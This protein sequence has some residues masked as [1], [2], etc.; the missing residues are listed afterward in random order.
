VRWGK[1]IRGYHRFVYRNWVYIADVQQAKFIVSV[2]ISL[3]RP[4]T[5][6]S[7]LCDLYY[8]RGGDHCF[9]TKS[10]EVDRESF[11][12]VGIRI[13]LCSDRCDCCHTAADPGY[14]TKQDIA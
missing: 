4:I 9:D 7:S 3:H 1:F 12:R 14:T 13:P 5:A 10:G 6:G 11:G 8:I 2:A